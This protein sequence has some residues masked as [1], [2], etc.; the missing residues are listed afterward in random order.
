M[1]QGEDVSDAVECAW[2]H[3]MKTIQDEDGVTTLVKKPKREWT[4]NEKAA[5]IANSKALLSIFNAM[6]ETQTK[7]ISNCKIAK[8][9]WDILENAFE[10]SAQVRES[11]LDHVE[12]LFEGM[13]MNEDET[14]AVYYNRFMDVVNQAEAFGMHFEE[15][16]LVRKMLK[17][18]T[19]NFRPKVIMLDEP[20]KLKNMTL[21][22]LYGTLVSYEMNYLGDETPKSM[23]LSVEDMELIESDE[24]MAFL[25]RKLSRMISEKHAAKMKYGKLQN[26]GGYQSV[27]TSSSQ[28]K[29]SEQKPS[30]YS[31][32]KEKFYG[33]K[34]EKRAYQATWSDNDE[35]ETVCVEEQAEDDEVVAFM[36]DESDFIK[37]DGASTDKAS[38][39][40]IELNAY[41]LIEAY[42]EMVLEQKKFV[43]KLQDEI[44]VLK[45]DVAVKSTESDA[46]MNENLRLKDENDRLRKGKEKLDEILS[47]GKPFDDHKGVGFCE[48]SH[49]KSTTF[50]RGG[51]LTN[52]KL[53]LPGK[54]PT[55]AQTQELERN[56]KKNETGKLPGHVVERYYKLINDVMS[57]RNIRWPTEGLKQNIKVGLVCIPK[58]DHKQMECNVILS[59]QESTRADRWYFDSG[60]SRHITKQKG[61][62][63]NFVEDRSSDVI[64]GDSARG[65]ISGYGILEK[66]GIPRLSKDSCEVY[67]DEQK[68]VMTG[69][70]SKNNC[71]L[72][73]YPKMEAL[74]LKD[75]ETMLWHTRYT[76]VDFL[77]EKSGAFDAFEKLSTRLMNE[78]KSKINRLRT[79]HGKE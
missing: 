28:R 5:G 63:K 8:E 37:H 62:L 14:I 34:R 48:S 75:D 33:K 1:L 44:E 22:E 16:R 77:R 70:R 49:R 57:G 29:Y 12:T 45:K 67:N 20:P 69:V 50:V 56:K 60:C 9:A 26:R 13:K 55:P 2:S 78:K 58:K 61:L 17:S 74:I 46:L 24:E 64:F 11:K 19:K 38:E 4:L 79:D 18:L 68:R 3:P 73:E 72:L 41:E 15:K 27:S 54:K 36:A 53:P 25:S 35:E 42:E 32:Q 23:A 30:N 76:W 66:E 6:D 31:K 71:Y 59:S 21:D 51:L 65:K 39:E 43:L 7:L 47:I 52:V 40:S 10:G